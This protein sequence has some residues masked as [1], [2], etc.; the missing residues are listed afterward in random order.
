MSNDQPQP[1][2]GEALKPCPMCGGEAAP[3]T[4]TYSRDHVND[5]GWKQDIFYG[6]NCIQCG[7]NNRG[8]VGWQTPEKAAEAWNRRAVAS[9]KQAS[10]DMYR[11]FC[12][13]L[14]IARIAMNDAEIRKVL[15]EID[16]HFHS[17]QG[18]H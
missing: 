6:V 8:I 12:V 7:L 15:D 3:N 16:G 18:G 17:M 13:R 5:Q 4:V 1:R 9:E 2:D 14:N 11:D 10:V